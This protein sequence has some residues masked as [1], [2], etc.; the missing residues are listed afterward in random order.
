MGHA[1]MVTGVHADLHAL[2]HVA[3]IWHGCHL[4]LCKPGCT[5]RTHARR[6]A[7]QAAAFHSRL[8]SHRVCTPP[9]RPRSAMRG[10]AKAD[11][12]APDWRDGFPQDLVSKCAPLALRRSRSVRAAHMRRACQ[13]TLDHAHRSDGHGALVVRKASIRERPFRSSFD[14][15]R[16]LHISDNAIL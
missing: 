14:R 16:Y 7:L 5:L 2:L 15:V 9:P 13:L 4:L 11:G 6:A 1:R 8:D 10:R 12:L 3:R